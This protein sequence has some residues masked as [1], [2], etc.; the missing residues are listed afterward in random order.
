MRKR[1]VLAVLVIFSLILITGCEGD[2]KDSQAGEDVSVAAAENNGSENQESNI[3]SQAKGRYMENDLQLPEEVTRIY[4]MRN[5]EDGSIGL[6]DMENGL[7]ISE[8][9]GQTWTLKNN[10]F[11]KELSEGYVTRAGLSSDGSIFACYAVSSKEPGESSGESGEASEA[12]SESGDTGNQ[13]ISLQY[14]YCLISA[15]GTFHPVNLESGSFQGKIMQSTAFLSDGTILLSFENIAYELKPDTG[16][17]TARYETQKNIA[18]MREIGD[19]LYMTTQDDIQCFALATGEETADQVLSEQVKEILSG[20]EVTATDSSFALLLCEGDSPDAAC[21]AASRGLYHHVI[22][23]TVLEEVIKGEL[24]SL[25][26]P[27]LELQG[28][29]RLPDG[30]FLIAFSG[31]VLK[32]YT[33]DGEA[34]AV[35]EHKVTVYS[36]E[37]NKGIRMGIV[38]YQKSHSDTFVKYEIG[39]T[40]TDGVTREDAIRN[41]NTAILSGEGPDILVLD[42]LPVNSY[43]EKGI[44]EDL[45]PLFENQLKGQEFFENIVNVYEKEGAYLAMPARFQF[46]VIMSDAKVTDK[47]TDLNSFADAVKSLR[48]EHESGSLMG[49]YSE[50]G[51]LRLLYETCVPAWVEQDGTIKKEELVTFLTKAK[52]IYEAESK[53]TSPEEL[54]VRLEYM[55][56]LKES[57][58]IKSLAGG[59]ENLFLNTNIRDTDYL[60]GKNRMVL[61]FTSGIKGDYS[62]LTSIEDLLTEEQKIKRFDGQSSGVFLPNTIL[63]V[64]SQGNAKEAAFDFVAAILSEENQRN[65]SG[66]GYPV[67][68]AAFDAFLENTYYSPD[69]EDSALSDIFWSSEDGQSGGLTVKWPSEARLNDL[70]TMVDGLTTPSITDYNLKAA[71]MEL[72]PNAL[73]GTKDVESVANEI[74]NK[75]QIYLSE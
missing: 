51:V 20:N 37:E 36:L 8:D 25:S 68:K 18:Q 34:S 28:L 27:A 67:Q 50:E 32:H 70:K 9:S 31:S 43:M 29:E 65:D 48:S 71:V 4:D 11:L 61:G 53:G 38:Q 13:D 62:M 72:A 59:W 44:L 7:Y 22:G 73:N 58:Y 45:S 35:P 54:T 75:M 17:L 69:N 3:E 15:D 24:S 55:E 40:G 10:S 1:K 14:N 47:I 49:A 16:E 23:G 74:I 21:L 5:L 39:M 41:L 30:S 6:L 66:N 12:G 42:G 2:K 33:Y 26:D 19:Y 60:E 46:P 52:E 56:S 57:S 64:N 63:G